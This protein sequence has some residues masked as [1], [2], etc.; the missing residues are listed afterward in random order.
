MTLERDIADKWVRAWL[1]EHKHD[2]WL[3]IPDS[4][5]GIKPFDGVLFM[6]MGRGVH[7]ALA[8]E[9]KVWRKKRVKFDYSTVEPHQMRELLLFARGEGRRSLILVYYE[10]QQKWVRYAP[11][12]G[13]LREIV[14]RR[15]KVDPK[16]VHLP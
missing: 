2:Y 8:I 6:E 16:E 11:S 14:A 4:A 13:K 15:R 9:F 10:H 3:R 12:E 1:A 5:E 7:A